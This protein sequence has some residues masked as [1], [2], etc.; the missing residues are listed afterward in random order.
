[1][2]LPGE[3]RFERLSPEDLTNLAVEA[4]D[5]PMHIG[6]VAVL[7]GR[8][9]LDGD[10]RLKFADL[11]SRIEAGLDRVPMLRKVLYRPGLLAG[12]PV[13]V[14]DPAFTLD[15][16]V[17]QV[18][19]A[20]PGGEDQLLRLTERLMQPTLD[21]SRPLWRIWFVTGLTA[22]RVAVVVKLHHAIADGLAAVRLVATL[23]DPPPAPAGSIDQAWRPTPP[24]RWR[25]LF[26]DNVSARVSAAAHLGRQLADP[27]GL[28]RVLWSA[29]TTWQGMTRAWAAPRTSL[30]API[31]SRRRMAVVHLDLARAKDAGHRYGGKVNDLV[32]DLITGGLRA[33]LLARGEP[34][35]GLVLHA[36]V[37]VSLRS[38][39]QVDQAGNRAGVV[40]VRLPLSEPDP[41]IRLRTVTAETDVAKRSQLAAGEQHLMVVL[42]KSGLMRYI[43]RRQHL[44][45]LIES[46]VT[47]PSQLIRAFGAPVHELIPIGVLAGNLTIAFLAFSYAGRLTITIW[48]DADRYPDL[49]VLVR[50]MDRD[51]AELSTLATGAAAQGD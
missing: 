43:T 26:R 13:W 49:P 21:R 27:A 18:R 37:A 15:R 41:G 19:L 30:N 50:A 33:L 44:T 39:A 9:L 16:H 29:S 14:D 3:A 31:G 32:L 12:R 7:D 38:Q 4:T 11:L 25:D 22:G 24:P 40:V 48:C 51:W 46:N 23:V 10:G 28:R 2:T 45:N 1:V 5:T 47:G 36:A 6:V 8:S 35:D 17:G 34:V 20:A 42:A